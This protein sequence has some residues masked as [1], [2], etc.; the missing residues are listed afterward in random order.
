MRI[1]YLILAG[2]LALSGNAIGFEKSH[3]RSVLAGNPCLECD[4]SG[5]NLEN[6]NLKDMILGFVNF[7][8]A[9]LRGA[10][11]RGASLDGAI[12]VGANMNGADLR[13]VQAADALFM[14]ANL[15]NARL[16]GAWLNGAQFGA[17]RFKGKNYPPA[18]LKG[19][20]FKGVNLARVRGLKPK[21]PV[22]ASAIVKGGPDRKFLGAELYVTPGA[23]IAP[24]PGGFSVHQIVDALG[25][26]R[27][28]WKSFGRGQWMV[29]VRKTDQMSMK[30]QTMKM[31]FVRYRGGG[32]QGVIMKRVIVNRQELNQG[33][34]FQ[35]VQ[36]LALKAEA[37]Q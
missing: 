35:L 25:T 26:G 18:V 23:G 13:K 5:A 6:A 17:G 3:L 22:P 32:G 27:K 24:G 2:F 10:N 28:S 29:T 37:K 31:L 19:T 8:G 15:T 7:Q 20:S 4:L 1:P 33:Q 12:F 9:N 21:K 36:R 34:I 16:D 11:L 30:R 14:G